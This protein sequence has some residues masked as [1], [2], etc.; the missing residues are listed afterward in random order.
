MI[1]VLAT[2]VV[3]PRRV[4]IP[5]PRRLTTNTIVT[6]QTTAPCNNPLECPPTAAVLAAIRPPKKKEKRP[7]MMP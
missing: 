6:I 3:T 5:A 2:L 1:A 7:A 4:P